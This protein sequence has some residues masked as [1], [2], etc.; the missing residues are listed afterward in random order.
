MEVWELTGK[1]YRARRQTKKSAEYERQKSLSSEDRQQLYSRIDLRVDKMLE[2]GLWDEVRSLLASGVPEK[3]T[4]M[5]A[6]GYKEVVAALRGE[7]SE[8][9]AIDA[10]KRES[11]RYAKRQLTW[12][13][14]DEGLH[15]ILWGSSPDL[16]SPSN[17]TDF[18]RSR[19][20]IKPEAKTRSGKIFSGAASGVQ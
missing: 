9:E 4:A 8:A 18:I 19:L 17:S 11:R 5:Q 15:W 2:A 6:I 7:C 13:R 10:I 12:L 20:R 14:R 16:H 3:C 1:P